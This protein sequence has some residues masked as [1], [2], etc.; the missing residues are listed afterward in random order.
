M[1]IR[2]SRVR[3]DRYHEARDMLVTE[4]M[5][6]EKYDSDSGIDADSV[7]VSI[8]ME[9]ANVKTRTKIWHKLIRRNTKCRMWDIDSDDSD[10]ECTG[11]RIY[12]TGAGLMSY[13]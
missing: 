5:V 11:S 2:F 12:A 13:E 6:R 3:R 4:S 7:H 1:G 8:D 10:D 9:T